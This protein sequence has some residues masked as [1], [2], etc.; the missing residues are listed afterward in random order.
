MSSFIKSDTGAAVRYLKGWIRTMPNLEDIDIDEHVDMVLLESDTNPPKLITLSEGMKRVLPDFIYAKV[1]VSYIVS[2][3]PCEFDD[4][5]GL[6]T[7]LALGVA[8]CDTLKFQGNQHPAYSEWTPGGT[9][10]E[11]HYDG[12]RVGGHNLEKELLTHK[13]RYV[14]VKVEE[15]HHA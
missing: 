9:F 11:A 7:E 14:V 4:A 6:I 2:D 15:V 5:L 8:S 10:V 3:A 12:V 1:R 13:G